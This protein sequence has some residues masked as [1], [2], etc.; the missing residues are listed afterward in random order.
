MSIWSPRGYGKRVARS[1]AAGTV[2][3][4]SGGMQKHPVSASAPPPATFFN[5]HEPGLS[6]ASPMYGGP[7]NAPNRSATHVGHN[8]NALVKTL[9]RADN[10][11]VLRHL[12]KLA[13][14]DLRLRFGRS[15]DA[16]AL[17]R[18]VDGIDFDN[19][20]LFGIHDEHLQLI[21]FGHLAIQAEQGSAELG[22]S[23]A[24]DH[25][26]HGHGSAVLQRA[27]LHASNHGVRVIY[28]HYLTENE[29]MRRLA[30][31]TGFKVVPEGTETDATK[32]I[33][34]ATPGSFLQ[35]ILYDQIAFVDYALK[36]RLDFLLNLTRPSIANEPIYGDEPAGRRPS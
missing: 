21:A 15:M 3:R 26:R 4:V 11:D 36:R 5:P 22:L 2:D 28:M 19:D 31:S 25:R 29:A 9:D 12:G 23:V 24:Q 20:K 14:D 6:S 32:S 13:P 34:S 7:N 35:E 10:G 30:Q 33:E 16:Q 1:V 17:Q 27:T 18:Y 8:A